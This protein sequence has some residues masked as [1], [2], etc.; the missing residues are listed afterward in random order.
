[1]RLW[2]ARQSQLP[3]PTESG[4]TDIQDTSL[5][6][7]STKPNHSPSNR[8]RTSNKRYIRWHHPVSQYLHQLHVRFLFVFFFFFLDLYVRAVVQSLH[9]SATPDKAKIW[10]RSS[11]D[12]C[13]DQLTVRFFVSFLTCTW[14]PSFSHCIS[15]PRPIKRR[16]DSGHREI[17]VGIR[18]R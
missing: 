15:L 18:S 9:L 14:G 5:Q 12:A 7:C 13:S 8:D 17:S 4:R 1:M 3:F 10:L 6:R 11:R 16:Y 2:T